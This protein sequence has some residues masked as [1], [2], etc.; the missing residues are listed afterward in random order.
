MTLDFTKEELRVLLDVLNAY[1]FELCN[2]NIKDHSI[3]EHLY[4]K[5]FTSYYKLLDK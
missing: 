3:Y 4:D 2:E 1:D 5:V